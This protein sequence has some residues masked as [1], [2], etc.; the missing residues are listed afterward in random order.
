MSLSKIR[1]GIR[2][3]GTMDG[4]VGRVERRESESQ[5]ERKGEFIR[6]FCWV[7]YACDCNF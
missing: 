5:G 1:Y 7:I 2:T 3:D 6:S 4:K